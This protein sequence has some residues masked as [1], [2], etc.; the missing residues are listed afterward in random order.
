MAGIRYI[1]RQ[2]SRLVALSV[3]TANRSA[4]WS[5]IYNR[6]MLPLWTLFLMPMIVAAF[7]T[8]LAQIE[9]QARGWNHLLSLPNMKWQVFMATT[10][11]IYLALTGMTLLALISTFVGALLGGLISGH[12]PTGE[13]QLDVALQTSF[14]PGS[15]RVASSVLSC[16]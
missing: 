2:R 11:M 6:F 1:W 12:P 15:E 10:V 4:E 16:R 3:A 9:F 8:L 14:L 5:S 7:T 13:I